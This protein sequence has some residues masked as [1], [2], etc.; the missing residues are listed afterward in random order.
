MGKQTELKAAPGPPSKKRFRFQKGKERIAGLQSE[1]QLH[2]KTQSY[3]NFLL[4]NTATEPFHD[5]L[6]LLGELYTNER[7]QQLF[8][9]LRRI[10]NSTPQLLHHLTQ[11]VAIL[12]TNVRDFPKD[13]DVMIPVLKL[14]VALA[15]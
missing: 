3:S 14:Y 15:K 9:K 2:A 10:T 1:L 6:A 13:P 12:E 5:E 11:V 4:A 8:R 7:F